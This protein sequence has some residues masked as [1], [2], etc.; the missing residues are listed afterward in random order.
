MEDLISELSK[1]SLFIVADKTTKVQLAR[2]EET[3]QTIELLGTIVDNKYKIL[4]LV[5]NS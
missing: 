3:R 1:S 5:G 4:Q 2:V